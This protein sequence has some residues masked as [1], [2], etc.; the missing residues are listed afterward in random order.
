MMAEFELRLEA[1]DPARNL[2]RSWRIEAGRDL[3]G[4]WI[5]HLRYGRIGCQGRLLVRSFASEEAARRHIQ[6]GIA[7]RSTA[8]RR[9][10]VTYVRL[11]ETS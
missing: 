2:F 9:I 8:P 10:G 3:F 6:A 5:V 11:Y 7:R 1:R 4:S